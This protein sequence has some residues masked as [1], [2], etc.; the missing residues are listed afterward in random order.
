MRF[1]ASIDVAAWQLFLQP[2]GPG[3]AVNSAISGTSSDSA[4]SDHLRYD[5]LEP[6]LRKSL[7]AREDGVRD[8][9]QRFFYIVS[10]VRC[11]TDAPLPS[12]RK[13]TQ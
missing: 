7:D 2:S 4:I 1:S 11:Y 12:G 3:C 10:D 6:A 5:V 13:I 8:T 9:S